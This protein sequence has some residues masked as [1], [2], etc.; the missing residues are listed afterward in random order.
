V[1][2]PSVA[3][4]SVSASNSKNANELA[5]D[6]LSQLIAALTPDQRRRLAAMLTG[7]Q[8]GGES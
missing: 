5:D 6:D 1:S 4:A 2:S 7:E 8:E 3:S